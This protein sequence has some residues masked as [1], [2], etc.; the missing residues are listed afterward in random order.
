[1]ECDRNRDEEIDSICEQCEKILA[2]DENE[3]A[4]IA[5]LQSLFRGHRTRRQVWSGKAATK[6][7]AV[8]RGHKER[9]RAQ[10]MLTQFL[11]VQAAYRGHRTRLR[12]RQDIGEAFERAQMRRRPRNVAQGIDRVLRVARAM[13]VQAVAV[14][15][16]S[17]L[18]QAGAAKDE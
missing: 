1:M 3:H 14:L 12:L 5:K 16:L 11:R 10:R 18:P 2:V 7:Q 15:F 6:L 8:F 4:R 17:L 9:D 13:P